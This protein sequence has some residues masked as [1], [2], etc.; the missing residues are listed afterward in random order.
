MI[1]HTHALL[2]LT[3]GCIIKGIAIVGYILIDSQSNSE[4]SYTAG[5]SLS[6]RVS[7]VDIY[8]TIRQHAC[9]VSISTGGLALQFHRLTLMPPYSTEMLG[10][11][12]LAAVDRRQRRWS[13]NT[14]D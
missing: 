14:E 9:E 7:A 6:Y 10:H 13:R 4:Q 2:I 3:G 1:Q 11:I 12:I 8:L 5:G